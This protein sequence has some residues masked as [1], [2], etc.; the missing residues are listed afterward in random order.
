MKVCKTEYHLQIA[1]E[2]AG[3]RAFLVY[4]R[5]SLVLIFLWFGG[6]K[7]TSYEANAISP[8][9]V[10]SPL[11]SW[12]NSLFGVTGASYF[13]GILELSTAAALIAGA[14]DPLCSVVGAAMSSVTYVITLTFMLTTP[15]ITE[16]SEGGFPALGAMPGQFLLKDSVLLAASICLLLASVHKFGSHSKKYDNMG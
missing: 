1:E 5:W 13:I 4:L 6:M 16:A 3:S 9:I 2:S 11:M 14:Y 15:G 10:N 12:I 7:F 8:F